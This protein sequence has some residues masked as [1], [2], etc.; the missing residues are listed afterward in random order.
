MEIIN[1]TSEDIGNLKKL[2]LDFFNAKGDLLLFRYNNVLRLLK[3]LDDFTEDDFQKHFNAVSLL[4]KYRDYLP[5]DFFIPDFLVK[6]DD[7]IKFFAIN[8]VYG[9]NLSVV[10]KDDNVSLERKKNYLKRIGTILRQM[11]NIRKNTELK[12]FYLADIH[13]DNFLVERDKQ[14]IYIVD[15]DS[16]KIAGNKSFPGRYLTNSSLIKYNNTK[17]QTLS[18]TDDLADYKIDENTDIYCYIIMILNY[19]YDGRVDRLSL[20]KFYDFINY[21]E[22]IK[23]NIE[24]IECFN[25][26]VVGGNN[27]NPCN[28][29]DTLTPKQVAGA[30]RLYKK[31]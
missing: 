2:S 8:Y 18:Q 22:D 31:K 20:D 15:L 3:T 6:V 28:Y 10:L 9:N 14:E 4:N 5:S 29:L 19:L 17:Y 30:R 27:I 12:N 23:V 26:I 16:R 7:I 25:K 21:L 11:E 1:M 13:E 24:L